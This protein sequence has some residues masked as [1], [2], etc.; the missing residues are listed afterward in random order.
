[1]SCGLPSTLTLHV[2]AILSRARTNRATQWHQQGRMDG[3]LTLST[4]TEGPEAAALHV[5]E[6]P[7][8]PKQQVVE[9]AAFSDTWV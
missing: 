5:C 7:E 1:M 3:E 6:W 2:S 4:D 9:K 8:V